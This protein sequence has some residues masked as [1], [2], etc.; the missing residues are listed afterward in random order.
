[1][2]GE[3][4][5]KKIVVGV[6]GG[7][8]AYKAVEVVSR[9]RKA[10]AEVH[11][12][13]TREA[14]QFVTELTFREISGRPVALDMWSKVTQFQVEHVALATLADLILVVPATANLLAKAA[15]GIADDML[16]TTLLA[17]KA[18]ICMAPSMNTVMYE[19]PVTQKNIATLRSRGV[20]ILEPDEGH[21]ACGTSG[22]GRLPEPAAIVSFV[23]N[24][25]RRQKEMTGRKLLVTAGGTIEPLDPVRFIGNR[26]T[27]RMGYA[28]AEEAACRGAEVV[29]ISGPTS[30]PDPC[31]VRV[32]RLETAC[33]MRDAVL[34]AFSSADAVIKAAAVADYRPAEISPHK[35]K[36]SDD[37]LVLHLVRNPDI[38]YELGQKKTHQ[39]LVGFAA[40]TRR[41][42][43]YARSKLERKNLDFIVANDVSEPDAGFAVETNRIKIFDRNGHVTAY[44]LKSK[45]ELAGIIL[46]H[47][48]SIWEN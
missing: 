28:I 46:D 43:E 26:S 34:Q 25:F 22:K 44:P 6:T 24:G 7:I 38:L 23:Q 18:P 33:E 15:A 48:A 42:D 35:I 36:K 17:T 2:L 10:G 14:A 3:L 31:G 9:L 29:L 47:V 8:A 30:L 12:I 19:N 32:V 1:M 13:M 16:T 21:L 4:S 37:D 41:V 45:R 5:G 40:E 11:V 39:I 27:G 20:Q